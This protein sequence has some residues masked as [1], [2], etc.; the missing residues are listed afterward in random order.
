VWPVLQ[1]WEREFAVLQ[2]RLQGSHVRAC[3]FVCPLCFVS[4]ARFLF[5]GMPRDT[6]KDVAR[7]T[8]SELNNL[9]RSSSLRITPRMD[10]SL[11]GYLDGTDNGRI[12][13][14]LNVVRAKSVI[15]TNC[16]DEGAIQ[17]SDWIRTNPV[18]CKLTRL[19]LSRVRG[20]A[21]S[22]KGATSVAQMLA[23]NTTLTQLELANNR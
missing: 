18:E 5:L 21:M 9:L 11:R 4:C 8:A 14:C 10:G 22:C 19:C 2:T 1:S 12:L 17:I 20:D 15:C 6:T 3:E 13:D 23:H 16:G 7:G